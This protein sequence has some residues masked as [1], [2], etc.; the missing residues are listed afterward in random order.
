MASKKRKRE[1]DV[2]L[3]KVYEEL[4]DQDETVRLNAARTL[5]SQ[6]FKAGVTSEEQTTNILRRLFRGL[7]SGRKAARLGFSVALTELLSQLSVTEASAADSPISSATIVHILEGE[8]TP[9]T[10]TSGQDGR[11]HYFGRI[12]GADAILKS[13]IFFAR[14]DQVQWKQLLDLIAALA[15][16]KPWLRQECGWILFSCISANTAV[17]VPQTFAIDTLEALLSHKLIRTPEGVAVWIAT[18]KRFPDAKLPKSAWKHEDPLASKEINALSTILKDARASQPDQDFEAQGSATWSANL[19]FAW[20]VVLSE[21]YA[22]V[23]EPQVS[24][25]DRVSFEKFWAVAVEESLFSNASST[26]RKSWGLNLWRRVMET[27]P[28]SLLRHTFTQAALRCFVN[29]LKAPERLLQR[30]ASRLAQ[31]FPRRILMENNEEE[32]EDSN[33]FISTCVRSFLESVSYGD[34]DLIT[35]TKTMQNILETK[36]DQVTMAIAQALEHLLESSV[37]DETEEL[38]NTRQKCIV[39]LQ[40]KVLAVALRSVEQSPVESVALPVAASIMTSWLQ[41]AYISPESLAKQ[42]TPVTSQVHELI[43]A[44]LGAGFEQ[45]L[46]LGNPGVRLFAESLLSIHAMEQS[47]VQMKIQFEDEVATAIDTAWTR[48]QESYRLAQIQASQKDS[49][50]NPYSMH[51]GLL[52]LYCLILFQVYNGETEAVEITR[53][54]IAFHDQWIASHKKSGKSKKSQK[55]TALME[56]DDVAIIEILLGF[57]SRPSKFLRR[58]TQQIFESL[59]PQISKDGL[60]SLCN[61]LRAKENA[62]G[63]N[64]MFQSADVDM[65]DNSDEEDLDSDVEIVSASSSAEEDASTRDSES[66][67]ESDGDSSTS[68]TDEEQDSESDAELAAFDAALASALGT[69]PLDQTDAAGSSSDS[70]SDADMGDDE[71]MELDEKLAEVFRARNSVNPKNKRKEAKDA[72]ENIVNFKN[73]VLDLIDTYLKQQYQNPLAIELIT[74]LLKLI[75]TTKTKQIADHA[76]NVL[77]NFLTKCKGPVGPNLTTSA[78][79]ERGISVL[80][81]IHEETCLQASNQHAAAASL[82][83]ILVTKAVA[84][85]DPPSLST[86]VQLYASTRLRQL[87]DKKCHVT[88][89]FFTDWNNWC[90]STEKRFAK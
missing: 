90:Q 32:K 33:G 45:A 39:G 37:V 67:S 76:N 63:Q 56:G 71:M 34:F 15:I 44:R 59:A 73:R 48:L 75:R 24:A 28:R 30:C 11:D 5:L 38:R 79:I 7:C 22:T 42:D 69:R 19:H 14:S 68:S 9:E 54:L 64:E 53:E 41:K 51:D 40:G 16:K 20:D 77:R 65:A 61:I 84:K 86:I 58:I 36:S 78:E 35:K 74:P 89:I 43:V 3:V 23:A 85:G 10:G 87:T 21:L 60:E 55:A 18:T 47:G 8:T 6:I 31:T 80:K 26:E 50:K 2:E 57:A 62:Q 12:F 70:E 13:G 88:P 81:L 25:R 1:V 82:S 46:R 52:L 66:E 4:A 83:S 29:S 72:K 27:A 17:P 49:E